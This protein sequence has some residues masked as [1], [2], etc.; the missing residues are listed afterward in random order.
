M[1]RE[2][3]SLRAHQILQILHLKTRLRISASGTRFRRSSAQVWQGWPVLYFPLGFELGFRHKA[4]F[5]VHRKIAVVVKDV[6]G[7]WLRPS[8]ARHTAANAITERRVWLSGSA[9][10][11][12]CN[13]KHLASEEMSPRLADR[14]V[15]NCTAP[16]GQL[17][18]DFYH[19]AF[20]VNWLPGFIS[21]CGFKFNR[22]VAEG[23]GR[24]LRFESKI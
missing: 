12:G 1:G 20:F 13:V 17:Q 8:L 11:E 16:R 4:L 15:S 5:F 21:L 18:T 2:F 3:E 19:V 22:L 7:V 23:A 9:H 10:A 14:T 24:K 6:C